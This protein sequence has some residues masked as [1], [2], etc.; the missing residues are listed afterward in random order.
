M[1]TTYSKHNMNCIQIVTVTQ[2]LECKQ[3]IGRGGTADNTS[4]NEIQVTHTMQNSHWLKKN[5]VEQ[6]PP[7]PH[8]Q[9]FRSKI[10]PHKYVAIAFQGLYLNFPCQILVFGPKRPDILSFAQKYLI[11]TQKTGAQQKIFR[12][13]GQFAPPAPLSAALSVNQM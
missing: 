5:F 11:N 1:A 7:T 10:F 8:R 9:L 4:R 12:G 13:P 6:P 3:S 2:R